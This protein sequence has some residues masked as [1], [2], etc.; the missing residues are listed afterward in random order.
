MLHMNYRF[1]SK[2]MHI[3][4]KAVGSPWGS[5]VRIYD[6]HFTP[7]ETVILIAKAEAEKFVIYINGEQRAV[8]GHRLPVTSITRMEFDATDDSGSDLKSLQIFY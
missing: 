4:E 3:N 6:L 8:F 2:R 7:G 5:E 1:Y